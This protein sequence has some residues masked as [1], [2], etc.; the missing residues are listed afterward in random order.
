MGARFTSR[1]RR[2]GRKEIQEVIS[3]I[4]V[5]CVDSDDE[6]FYEPETLLARMKPPILNAYLEFDHPWFDHHERGSNRTV[7]LNRAPTSE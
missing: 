2:L 3:E 7:H 5:S 6:W 1:G 4:F